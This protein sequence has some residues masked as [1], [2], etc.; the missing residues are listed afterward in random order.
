MAFCNKRSGSR[1]NGDARFALRRYG[2]RMPSCTHLPRGAQRVLMDLATRSWTVAERDRLPDDGNR[3]EVVDGEPFVTPTPAPRHQVLVKRLFLRIHAFVEAQGLG[4]A[5]DSGTDV[6]FSPRDVVVPDIAVYP[7][8][9]DAL[10]RNWADAPKPTLVVE[11]RS[12]ST[13]RRDVGPKRRLYVAREVP[14]YWIVDGDERSITIARPGYDDVVVHD[15][16]R[17][18]PQGAAEAL[19][20]QL[21]EVL[22][23]VARA[24]QRPYSPGPV[25]ARHRNLPG[26]CVMASRS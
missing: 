5:F 20:V 21:A 17:W 11:V 15:V 16:L 13:W 12:D 18:R 26:F 14:E 22:R 10:P 6:I 4:C 25:L 2:C 7:V 8:V 19:E 1:E 3:Y 24:C 9:E 23:Q